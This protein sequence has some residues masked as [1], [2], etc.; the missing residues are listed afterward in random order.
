MMKTCFVNMQIGC[1]F[2]FIYKHLRTFITYFFVVNMGFYIKWTSTTNFNEIRLCFQF[3]QKNKHF[4]IFW[5]KI[6]CFWPILQTYVDSTGIT[7]YSMG[8]SKFCR[9]QFIFGLFGY[10]K[11]K[12]TC[13]CLYNSCSQNFF[14]YLHMHMCLFICLFVYIYSCVVKNLSTPTWA[15]T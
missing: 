14:L 5:T 11:L 7:F 1:L 3:L 2:L 8:S 12:T 10:T 4:Y 15:I 13:T 6:W 9:C